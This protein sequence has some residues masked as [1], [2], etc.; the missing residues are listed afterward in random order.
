MGT[1]VAFRVWRDR[2]SPAAAL[3]RRDGQ[4]QACRW[5]GQGEVGLAPGERCWGLAR[6]GAVVVRAESTVISRWGVQ[7]TVTKAPGLGLTLIRGR[8]LSAVW[9]LVMAGALEL[10]R[11]YAGLHCS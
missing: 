2:L 11:G 1:R 10:S 8:K 4:A 3:W 9:D 6:G 7:V 5:G